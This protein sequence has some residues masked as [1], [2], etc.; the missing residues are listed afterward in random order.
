[1]YSSIRGTANAAS[2]GGQVSVCLPARPPGRGGAPRRALAKKRAP[3]A[4]PWTTHP[5]PH[6]GPRASCTRREPEGGA[7]NPRSRG[8]PPDAGGDPPLPPET[9]HSGVC[10]GRS[11]RHDGWAEVRRC[12]LSHLSRWTQLGTTGEVKIRPRRP[13]PTGPPAHPRGLILGLPAIQ[14]ARR[15]FRWRAARFWREPLTCAHA[16]RVRKQ[17]QQRGT[18]ERRCVVVGRGKP[19]ERGLCDRAWRG[20]LPPAR[21][22]PRGG[23]LGVKSG[24]EQLLS[25]TRCRRPTSLPCRCHPPAPPATT[26]AHAAPVNVTT[27]R[28]S[29]SEVP[30]WHTA[31]RC[32]TPPPSP[33]PACLKPPTGRRPCCRHAAP[34]RRG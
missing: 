23:Q 8:G 11:R 24:W 18:T 10:P 30:P 9:R 3:V 1:M 29:P 34:S 19:L 16:G 22:P 6:A 20:W 33:L 15:F 4:S 13:T 27:S 21:P 31:P 25:P 14:R 7:S 26:L 12:N 17:A 2:G 5:P 32:A 28:A